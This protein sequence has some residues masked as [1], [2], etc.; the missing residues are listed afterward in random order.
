MSGPP[1]EKEISKSELFLRISQE[2]PNDRPF[3]IV[4]FPRKDPTTGE[5]I[6]KL[7]IW[8]LKEREIIAAR[9][10]AVRKAKEYVKEKQ[11]SNEILEG[12]AQVVNDICSTEMLVRCCRDPENRN[13]PIFPSGQAV[14][15]FLT[16]D[17]MSVLCVD[18]ATVQHKL[19]PI[20]STMSDVEYE[21]W[22]ERLGEG[23]SE[24]PLSSLSWELRTALLMRMAKELW[25]SRTGKSSAGSPPVEPS[26]EPENVV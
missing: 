4:N 14:R 7:A 10:E 11:A 25:I 15:E 19:G 24:L 21:A 22:V 26:S 18:Y 3:E 13:I 8:P 2:T 12:Y 23:G 6:G 1:G 20:A 9:A 16:S 17:E 5:P